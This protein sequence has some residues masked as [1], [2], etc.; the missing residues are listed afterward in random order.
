MKVEAVFGLS[1]LLGFVAFGRLTQLY[2]WP[3]LRRMPREAALGALL[4]PHWFRFVG[5]SFLVPGVV[6][7][8]LSADF[9][10]PAAFG[11]MKLFEISLTSSTTSPAAC[12]GGRSSRTMEIAFAPGSNLA[13]ASLDPRDC[14]DGT[15]AINC[16]VYGCRGCVRTSRVGPLSTTL[17][18][19]GRLTV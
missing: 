1:V 12:R 11:A 2:L 15:A 8:A 17:P 16:L 7:P 4:A 6:S 19:R 18:S 5:L 13:D 14:P 3:R 9:A 10:R